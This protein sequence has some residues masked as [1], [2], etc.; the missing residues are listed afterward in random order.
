MFKRF[1]QLIKIARRLSISG[2]VEIV[3]EIYKLPV[4]IIY[5]FKFLSIGSQKNYLITLNNLAK[6]YALLLKEWGQL[7]LKLGQF[8][9]TR[10]DIIGER[11]IVTSGKA[12]R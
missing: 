4:G 12:T 6:D 11:I 7:S 9:A 5:L 3:D 8:L 1:F 2:A 10:P